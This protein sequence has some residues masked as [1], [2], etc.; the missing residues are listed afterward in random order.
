LGWGAGCIMA[1]ALAS[2]RV[3]RFHRLLLHAPVAPPHVQ[4]RTRQLAERLGLKGCPAVCFLP[5]RLS[6]MLWSLGRR[7]LLLVPSGL[8]ERLAPEQ[9]DS[10]LLHELAHLRRRD[11][12]TRLLEMVVT[13]LYW[14]FPVVWWVRSELRRAEE[15]CCDAWVVWALGSSPKAYATALVET[16][17]FLSEA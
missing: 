11:H 17:D 1:L 8:W 14:W 15:D 13:A 4:E 7:S 3:V 12:W 9:R 2:I 10:L 5:G 6:P 16:L